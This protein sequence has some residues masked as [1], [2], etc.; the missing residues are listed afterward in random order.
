MKVERE[1]LYP[2]VSKTIAKVGPTFLI[3]QLLVNTKIFLCLL[4]PT[5]NDLYRFGPFGTKGV[6]KSPPLYLKGYWVALNSEL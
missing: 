3:F 1:I 4:L 5:V 6:Q 2:S